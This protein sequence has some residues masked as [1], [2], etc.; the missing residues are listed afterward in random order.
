VLD[1][2]NRGENGKLREKHGGEIRVVTAVEKMEIVEGRIKTVMRV[3]TESEMPEQNEHLPHR[4]EMTS[5][6]VGQEFMKDYYSATIQRADLELCLRIRDGKGAGI[7]LK[8]KR[9]YTFKTV[10][11]TVKVPRQRIKYRDSGRS[12]T[13]S[14]RIWKLPRQVKISRGLKNE[15]SNIAMKESYGKTLK[16]IEQETGEAGILSKSSVCKIFH[17]SGAELGAAQAKRAKK[18]FIKDKTA[19]GL[20][21]RAGAQIG[22]EHFCRLYLGIE[23]LSMEE[24]GAAFKQI[25]WEPSIDITSVLPMAEQGI[26]PSADAAINAEIG[27][28]QALEVAVQAAEAAIDEV[29]QGGAGSTPIIAASAT[30]AAIDEK[31]PI[32]EVI[33][34]L[35]EVVIRKQQDEDEKLLQYN[36]TIKAGAKTIYCSATTSGQLIFQVS[37]VLA[38]MGV[39]RGEKKLLVIGDGA[40]WINNF[41]AGCATKEK[42]YILC[43]F[44]L[45]EKCR[46]MI[47][48][49]IVGLPDRKIVRKALFKYLWRGKVRGAL[50]YLKKLV[51]DVEDGLS[52]VKIKSL[53]EIAG[54]KNYIVRRAEYIPD[55]QAR[56]KSGEWIASTQIEKF[57]DFAVSARCKRD[58]SRWTSKGVNAIAVLETARRN[59]ELAEWQATGKLPSWGELLTA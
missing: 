5:R 56:R 45:W 27:A 33:A 53:S 18:E 47:N 12:E 24:V 26:E 22:E 32:D 16:Q 55:Y 41:V 4:V 52:T 59:G 42:R 7:V 8:G 20:I 30:T 50:D 29:A 40:D 15:T 46:G 17:N 2:I 36:G 14:S 1:T 13:P 49:A 28:G 48:D 51:E 37:S 31:K 23:E 11:G 57:N 9:A 34:Q 58:G 39:H 35:D 54:L 3:E 44:H 19:R 38:A 10:L 21:G 43:W 6:V 25:Q